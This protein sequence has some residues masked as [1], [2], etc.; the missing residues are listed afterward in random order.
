MVSLKGALSCWVTDSSSALQKQNAV[1]E[2]DRE[3]G[4]LKGKAPEPNLNWQ[5][6]PEKK[7]SARSH[8]SQI[9]LRPKSARFVN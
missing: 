8:R 5:M 3:Q 6:P 2:K 9:S 7:P 4:D 1:P